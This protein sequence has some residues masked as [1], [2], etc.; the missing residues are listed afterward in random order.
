MRTVIPCANSSGKVVVEDGEPLLW[1]LNAEDGIGQDV[2]HLAIPPQ[3]LRDLGANVGAFVEALQAR[4]LGLA[5]EGAHDRDQQRQRWQADDDE[6]GRRA[7]GR[8]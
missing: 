1:H 6:M 4:G 5:V 7:R 2:W 3:L 8:L